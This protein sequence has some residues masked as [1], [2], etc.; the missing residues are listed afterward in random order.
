MLG[1]HDPGTAQKAGLKL[2]DFD[3]AHQFIFLG[4]RIVRVNRYR[5]FRLFEY[6][7]WN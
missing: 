4:V 3:G 6:G 1:D 2:C 5:H 7:H